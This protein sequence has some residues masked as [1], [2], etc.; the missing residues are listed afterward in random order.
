MARSR[1]TV[2]FQFAYPVAPRPTEHLL[3]SALHFLLSR[4]RSA[5]KSEGTLL[6]AKL[7]GTA[8]HGNWLARKGIP[9]A[10]EVTK[11]ATVVAVAGLAAVLLS[12]TTDLRR[13]RTLHE[14][15]V[16]P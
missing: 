3:G 10:G 9:P 7:P 2:C 11:F 12:R 4:A 16:R 15:G 14:Q 8:T 13:R 5:P 1:R 6:E